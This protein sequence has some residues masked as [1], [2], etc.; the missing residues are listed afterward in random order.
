MNQ[1]K[2]TK[3]YVRYFDVGLKNGIPMPLAPIFFKE[4]KI[5]QTIIPVIFIKNEVFLSQKLNEVDLATKI[6][7]LINQINQVNTIQTS[8]IQIDCDWSLAS[9]DRYLTFLKSLKEK[10]T[11]TISATIRLHQIKYF[12]QT[13]VPPVDYGVLMFYNMGK[14]SANGANSIYDKKVALQYLPA[15]KNYPLQLKVALPIFSWMVHSRN[16][17]I[18]NLISK[19]SRDDFRNN[20]TFEVKNNTISVK[21]NGLF[22]G[23][24][25]KKGDKLHLEEITESNLQEIKALLYDY[26][27]KEPQEIIYYDLDENNL[28]KY[29]NEFVF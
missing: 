4:K 2:V 28:K 27:D 25:F 10:W 3:L 6:I 9:R 7:G 23:F 5:D 21:E 1:N 18:V 15:L 14:L 20:P 16:D 17:Q 8:E 29:Q 26:M 24:F 13:K 22:K 11:K 12:N 19:T